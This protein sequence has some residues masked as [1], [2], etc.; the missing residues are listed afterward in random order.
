MKLLELF[1]K[2]T[3]TPPYKLAF[4][5]AIAGISNAAVLGIINVAAAQA[6]QN[7][8]SFQFV[9]Y[10]LIAIALYA[11]AQTFVM[12]TTSREVETVLHRVRVR[13]ADRVLHS[14]LV[15][16]EKIGRSEI[17]ASI[18]KETLTI[19]NTASFLSIG[20]QAGILVFFSS[21]YIAFLSLTAF[22]V[23]AVFVAIAV[24]IHFRR[25]K[26]LLQNLHLATAS[27]NKL[28]DALTDMLDG[29]KEVKINSAL[30][31]GLFR[32]IEHIS[33]ETAEMKIRTQGE[34]ARHFIFS[35]LTFLMLLG[36]MVFIVPRLSPTHGQS[37]VQLTT[38]ILFLIG[39]IS[40]LVSTIPAIAVANT[41]AENIYLLEAALAGHARPREVAGVQRSGFERIEFDK[42]RFEYADASGAPS[43][44]VGPLDLEIR[45][46]EVLFIVGGNGSGKST[47]LK[48]LTALYQPSSGQIRIDGVA[49]DA[50]NVGAYRSLFAVIFSD[51]HL[52]KRLYGFA[53][54]DRARIEELL[55]L[56]EIENKTRLADHEFETLDLSAGQRK[57]LALLVSFLED[58]P[59]YVFDEWAADQDPGFRRKFY[60]Q[61]LL[62]LTQRGKTV[63]AVTHDDKYFGVADR[64]V[65]MEEGRFVDADP[66]AG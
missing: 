7:A 17:Y 14:D 9:I 20:V 6:A 66:T 18:T 35:Q 30:G 38:S 51:Y 40:S 52:F 46:H 32:S 1:R 4:M 63:I 43:F 8:Y 44:V 54:V 41:S 47:F 58:K 49:L 29:F 36:T 15:T 48:L 5:A 33:H 37:V 16:M 64:R 19:S 23:S 62:E 53:E 13:I 28:F 56:M 57:R 25:R 10:F 26:E 34:M 3:T 42:V 27:E 24:S 31:A 61:L 22:I 45:A 65:K 11:A 50:T 39:P 2:E 59:V 21:I 55:R 12:L 60:E